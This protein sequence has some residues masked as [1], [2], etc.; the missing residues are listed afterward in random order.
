MDGIIVELSIL[1]RETNLTVSSMNGI[2]VELRIP[3]RETNLTIFNSRLCYCRTMHNSKGG[4]SD[5]FCQ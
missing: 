3:V 4:K 2:I 5:H 1:V